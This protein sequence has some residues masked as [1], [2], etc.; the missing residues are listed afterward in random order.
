M[1]R[2]GT[3]EEIAQ[4]M[5]FLAGESALY[6]TGTVLTINGGQTAQ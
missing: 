6:V 2:L 3:L 1:G 4:V 5:C